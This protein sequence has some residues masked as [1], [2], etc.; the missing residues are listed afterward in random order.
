MRADFFRTEDGSDVVATA[1]W[2]GHHAV[3]RTDDVGVRAAIERIFR[4]TPV[5]VDDASF[6]SLGAH[7]ASVIQPGTT[8]WFR[9]A[10]YA[11]AGESGL[12][13]RLI[14]EVTGQG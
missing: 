2:D 11:R 9:A 3:V 8:E 7:G 14:P 5:I 12:R 6:R 4:A 13:A 1:S 10:A